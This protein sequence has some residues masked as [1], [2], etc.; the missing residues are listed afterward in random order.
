M[1]FRKSHAAFSSLASSLN[2][3]VR[4]RQNR[5]V[6]Q[7]RKFARKRFLEQLEPRN[8]MALNILSVTPADGANDWALNTNLTITFDANVVKGQGNIHVVQN[9]TGTLGVAVD[10]NSPTVTI[11]GATVTVPLPTNLLPAQAY[12]VYV[13][14]GTFLDTTLTPIV[15]GTL[16]TQNFDFLP[17]N[18]FDAGITGGDGT[19]YTLVPPLNYSVDNTANATG[20]LAPFRGW[21]FMDKNSWIGQAG[22]QA[23]SAFTK[24]VG[25]VALGDPDQFDD[26]ANSGAFNSK[27][28]SRP[29]KLTGVAANS[30]VLEFDSSFR[31][32]N[33]QIGTLD[34]RFD[35]GAWTNILTLNPANTS[36]DGPGAGVNPVNLNEHLTSGIATG[37]STGGTGNGKGAA[38]FRSIQNPAGAAN[39]EL[40]WGVTGQNTWWW[41][42]D[43][44]QVKGTVTGTP[45]LGVNSSTFWNLD[46]P[47]LTMGIDKASISE[48]GGTA[49][50]TLTRNGSTA[51]ALTVNL[52]AKDPSGA[53]TTRLSVP[54][55]VTFAI[56]S[57]TATYPI[58]GID[59]N[60]ADRTQT[61]TITATATNFAPV[62]KSIDVIDDEGPKVVTLS[63]PDNG[64]GFDYRSNLSITFDSAVKKGNGSINIVRTNGN[65]LVVSLPVSSAAVTFQGGGT[66]GTTVIIDPPANLVG[67]TDYYVL[68]DDGTFVSNTPIAPPASVKTV[69]MTQNFDLMTLGALTPPVGNGQNFT[70]TPPPGFTI[71]DGAGAT[72]AGGNADFNNWGFFNKASWLTATGD[73]GRG[74][75]SAGSGVIAVADASAWNGATPNEMDVFLSTTPI[76]LGA[77]GVAAGSVSLEFDAT[78]RDALPALGIIEVS[79]GGAFIELAEFAS[80]AVGSTHVVINSAG[81]TGTGLLH[82]ANL[83]NPAAGNMR[84]RISFQHT[85]GGWFAVDNLKVFGSLP[86]LAFQGINN[87]ADWNFTAVVPT[88]S[89][90][91]DKASMSENGGTATGTVTRNA[92]SAVDITV[93]LSSNDT[94]EATVPASVVIPADVG[95]FTGSASVTFPITAVDDA[96]KDGPQVVVITASSAIVPSYVSGTASITVLDDDFPK[97]TAFSPADDSTAV[98]VGTN[99]SVTFT[100]DVKKGNGFVHIIRASDGKSAQDIDIQSSAVTIAGPVVTINPP[101]DL[102]GLTNYYVAFDNGAILNNLLTVITGT[103]LLSQDFELMTLGPAVTETVGLTPDGKDWTATPPAGYAVDNSLMPPGGVPEW[104]GWTFA[105]KSFWET[106]G[107]QN[108]SN[109]TKGQGTIAVG[110]TDEW[111]DLPQLNNSFN[112]FLITTPINLENV[113]ANTVV[114]EFDSSFRPEGAMSATLPPDNQEGILQVSYNGG[115]TWNEL[116]RYNRTNTDGSATAPNVNEHKVVNVPNPAASPTGSM[117]FRY[118]LTGTNDW[119]WAIDNLKVTA[120]TTGLASPGIANSDATTWN[121]ATAAAPTLTLSTPASPISEKGGVATI[122]LSRNGTAGNLDVTLTSSDPTLATVPTTVTIPDTQSSITFAVTAVDDLFADGLK[123]VTITASTTAQVAGNNYVSGTSIVPIADNEVGNVAITEIMFNPAGAE[124]K[125]E[126]MELYNRGTFTLDLGGWSFDDEDTTDWGAI[127]AGTLLA[128]GQFAVVFNSSFGSITETIFRTEW[129]VP[130]EAVVVGVFWGNLGNTPSAVGVIDENI[131]FRDAGNVPFDTVNYDDDGTIWPAAANG[132]SIYLTRVFDNNDIGTNWRSSAVGVNGAINPTNPAGATYNVADI[133]SPGRGPVVSNTAY[134]KGSAYVTPVLDGG[135]DPSKRVAKAGAAAQTMTFENV[136]NY[137]RGI[138]GL[139]VDVPGLTAATLTA[140]DIQLKMSPQGSFDEATNP[141]SGWAAAPPATAIVVTPG[142]A[143]APARVRFEWPDNAIE[144]RWLEVRLLANAAIGVPAVQE[145]YLGHLRGDINGALIGGSY[146]VLNADLSAALPVGGGGSPGAVSSIRDVDKNGFVLNSDFIAI[147]QGIV[148][149]LALTNITIPASGSG[150]ALP[151]GATSGI[152]APPVSPIEFGQTTDAASW[153]VSNTKQTFQS[154]SDLVLALA[155]SIGDTVLGCIAETTIAAKSASTLVSSNVDG[156]NNVERAQLVDDFFS[157]LDR[158]FKRKR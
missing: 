10:V 113:V 24:G 135:F 153:V 33:T 92:A 110:E 19:D 49:T 89:V 84:F 87:P 20:G 107:G 138:N 39:M 133:G 112:S 59:N 44:L 22:D 46:I 67:G 1:S 17:L 43:N 136:S 150:A 81:E 68:V 25:T 119:W 37:V 7:Q 54:P 98:P 13:D 66:S 76:D 11:A 134:Y 62:S 31:P 151:R 34:V 95:A 69:L 15:G 93:L 115:T 146:N 45:F 85:R 104:R 140:A 75:F 56:G 70:K 152:G 51:N 58:T 90:A 149:G 130:A 105:K 128:P 82:L 61:V 63:P 65:L 139:I 4:S 143:T 64:L 116:F 111:D 109:F 148:N 108:R 8:L 32:E 71:N 145:F 74:G 2:R 73:G 30:V 12:T 88:F 60:L 3:L 80:T 38:P 100:E 35:G 91:I 131:V 121:F 55:T 78:F 79:Y 122:T 158:T 114:L 123:N 96:L 137:T 83:V 21:S 50:G 72:A 127:P 147:R 117:K 129:N 26:A 23:R 53:A 99:L 94:T 156:S 106:E 155:G 86:A 47:V 29:I 28:I 77:S 9:S 124:P 103:P 57:L 142:T 132:P 16:L 141:P 154:T 120:S 157:D 18:P 6:E 36:N 97:T 118:G 48:N 42:I 144:N 126:W 125:T 40:R 41:A 5:R 101:V 52:V 102:A 14:S 27:F